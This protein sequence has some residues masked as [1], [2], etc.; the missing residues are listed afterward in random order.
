[1]SED[2]RGGP[3]LEKSESLIERLEEVFRETFQDDEI[4][5][6]RETRATDVEGWDSL[7]HVT[8]I[9]NVENAF[10]VRFRSG[11]V[12]ALENVGALLDLIAARL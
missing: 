4:R 12:A 10:R 1:M 8:L 6:T 2:D 5:I 3:A 7:M 9:L 11:E